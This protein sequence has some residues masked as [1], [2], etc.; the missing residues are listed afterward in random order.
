MK[1]ILISIALIIGLGFLL[2]YSFQ[3]KILFLP[4][5]LP[6]SYSFSFSGNYEEINFE[7][8]DKNSIN[9]LLFK[10]DSSKGIIYY[11]HG[12]GGALSGWGE[13]A[14][15]Y[16][17]LGYDVLMIDYRGYGKSTGK[18]KSLEQLFEDNQF[19]YNILKEHY[20]ENKI[21][22][23]GYSLGSGL[24]SKLASE[25]Q[26][27]LLILQA[28]YYSIEFVMN[29]RL[30]FIPSFILKYNINTS[31]YLKKADMPVVIFHGLEDKTISYLNALKLQS[32][33]KKSDTL[34]SIENLG[35]A[36][37]TENIIYQENLKKVLDNF[38]L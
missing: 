37:M 12:N 35:H 3:E 17:N 6:S 24:A 13:F 31:E 25:N 10:A 7:T 5:Q 11:L 22:L 29:E 23:L 8:K 33:F 18:I 27:Q 9:A 19:I 4:Y 32:E 21:T 34:I 2:L 20:G 28:P 1:K 26:P 36:G 38:N 16:T 15:T 14:E 30:P